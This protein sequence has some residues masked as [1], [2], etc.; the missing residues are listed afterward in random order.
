MD[1]PS[2]HPIDY[3]VG[4]DEEG[5]YIV[6]EDPLEPGRYYELRPMFPWDLDEKP[7]PE[8]P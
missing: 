6:V 2:T 7:A 5:K 8:T 1:G 3:F 4:R